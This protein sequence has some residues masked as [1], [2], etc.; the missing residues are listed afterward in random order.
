[1]SNRIAALL[2]LAGDATGELR[3]DAEVLLCH[4][5][6]RPRSY[7]Y[8]WPEQELDPAQADAFRKVL[9]AR[10]EG[11]PVAYLTG[12]RE[13]WSLALGVTHHTLIPRPET[14]RL[15]EIALGLPLPDEALVVDLGTGSGAVALALASERKNWR[16]SA[17]DRSEDALAVARDNA[18]RLGLAVRCHAGDWFTPVQDECFDLV[19]SNPPYLDADDPHLGEGDLRFE[20]R[21]ALVARGGALAAIET[22]A[23]S[24]PA[25]LRAG[26]WLLFEHGCEQGEA[27]A[28]ILREVGF[29]GVQT[30][31]DM[32]GLDR[33]SGGRWET[34]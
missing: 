17:V 1:M 2:A 27:V 23:N 15:V 10:R 21:D 7:L 8:T 22:I 25:Q 20:P 11:A 9:A 34:P 24:A 5:L 18:Q 26:G 4:V 28:A 19:I 13:F 6:Q 16:I 12:T 29:S 33:V 14:E 3:R 30:W 32:A 31:Q